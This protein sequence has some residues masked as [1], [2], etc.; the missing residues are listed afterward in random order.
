MRF[1]HAVAGCAVTA[2]VLAA[3]SP[4]LASKG[5]YWGTA[6]QPLRGQTNLQALTSLESEIGRKFHVYRFYRPLNGVNLKSDVAAVMKQRG[7][8]VYLNVTSEIGSRCVAWRSVAAGAYN[9]DLHRIARQ[10][11]SYRLTVYFSWNHEMEHN[12]RT[13]TPSEYRA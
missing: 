5:A 8:P 9:A 2:L 6:V 4:A 13:G 12:C 7:Q 10:V 11:R 3:A 1:G